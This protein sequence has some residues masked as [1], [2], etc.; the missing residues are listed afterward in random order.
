M[1]GASGGLAVIDGEVLRI[2]ETVKGYTVAEIRKPR[3]TKVR[4]MLIA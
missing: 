1:M 3:M 4:M 2:G